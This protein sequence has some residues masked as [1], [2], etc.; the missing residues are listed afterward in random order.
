MA[1]RILLCCLLL[2]LAACGSGDEGGGGPP[3]SATQLTVRVDPDGDGPE[4]AKEEQITCAQPPEGGAACAAAADLRPADFEP[5][6]DDMACTQQF[7][8]PETA[9]VTG[10]LEG[11]EVDAR[12]SRAD[13]CEIARWDKVAPLLE[14][15]G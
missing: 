13:G 1:S 11:G 8:G 5:T 9:T 10:T 7:G 15:V 4:P 6:P 12:F 14:A 2:A 3:A